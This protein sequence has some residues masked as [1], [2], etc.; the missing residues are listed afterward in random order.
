M[1]KFKSIFGEYASNLQLV[2]DSKLNSFAPT[3]YPKYFGWSPT[4]QSLTF[5]SAIGRARIEAMASIVNRDSTTPLR[6]RQGLE[7]LSGEIPAIKEMFKMQESDYREFLSLQNMP[8]DDNTKR[9]QLLDFLFGDVK[10]VGDAAHKRLDAM[11][12]EAISTGFI[13][14][15]VGNNPDGLV[16]T[17]AVPLGMPPENFVQSPFTWA[18]P[19]TATPI[20]DIETVNQ[21][22]FEK[23]IG[24]EKVLMSM[25]LFRK[26]KKA[27]EVLDT[28]QAFYYSSKPGGSF[29]P[30]AITAL[31][32][33][34][35]ALQAQGLPYIEI[36]NE[37][38][39]I[40]KDGSITVFRAFNENNAVFV[41]GGQLGTIKN[42]LAIEQFRPVTQVGYG[43]YNRAVISK[44]SENE[45]FGEW[46]KVELNAFPAVEAIDSM[47]I[48]TASF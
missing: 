37:A 8:V 34:N 24:L 28:L 4:Q 9:I 6:S 3:W 1:S 5:Q 27:K 12:L 47:Y 25:A 38:T 18:N 17:S 32:K 46:T 33:V 13:T 30:V 2:I 36:V 45:P 15:T 11:A 42:A 14:V 48:L 26:F 22:A 10:K 44:W 40:E 20:S 29:N 16:L 31:D 41:P 7:K 43:N 39:G 23:G 19:T 21:L 35:E